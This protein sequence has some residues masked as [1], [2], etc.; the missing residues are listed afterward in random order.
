[1]RER[2]KERER[3]REDTHTQSKKYR[4]DIK[5]L[6]DHKERQKREIVVKKEE[7]MYATG[8]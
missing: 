5:N 8:P 6:K 7:G 2:E 1:M 4:K 3:G